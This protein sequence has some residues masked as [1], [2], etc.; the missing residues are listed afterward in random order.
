MHAVKGFPKV[1]EIDVQRGVPPYSLLDD[2]HSERT[3]DLCIPASSES[4]LL[5][6]A[7]MAAS[8]LSRKILQKTSH[9]KDRSKCDASSVVT[10]LEVAFLKNLNNQA[11]TP[12]VRYRVFLP[13]VFK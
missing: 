6:M 7:P 11:F 8:F 3:S 2:A 9:G 12:I 10:V 5:S 13:D 4:C 1:D